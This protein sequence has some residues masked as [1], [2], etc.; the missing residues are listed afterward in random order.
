LTAWNDQPWAALAFGGLLFF[1]FSRWGVRRG[2]L[3]YYEGFGVWVAR[4]RWAHRLFGGRGG[5]IRCDNLAMQASGLIWCA[6][7]LAGALV[8]SPARSTFHLILL[9]GFFGAFVL[10]LAVVVAVGLARGGSRW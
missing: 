10:M 4:W 7:G 2:G 9:G 1:V 6:L 3:L 8:P 5:R